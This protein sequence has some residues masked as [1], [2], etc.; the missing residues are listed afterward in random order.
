MF[1]W[2]P[3]EAKDLSR[4]IQER[5]KAR[6]PKGKQSHTLYL[7]DEFTGFTFSMSFSSK[8][9][10]DTAKRALEQAIIPPQIETKSKPRLEE[11]EYIS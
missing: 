10:M 11:G 7:T 1:K 5:F 8:K 3:K 6:S 4:K 9:K 2:P